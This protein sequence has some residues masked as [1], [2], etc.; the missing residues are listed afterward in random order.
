MVIVG[1]FTSRQCQIGLPVVV[2]RLLAVCEEAGCDGRYIAAM[3]TLERTLNEVLGKNLVTNISAAIGAALAEPARPMVAIV[4]GSKVSTKLTVLETLSDKVDR[5]I[6][7]GGINGAVA[8]A[9]L[10]GCGVRVALID[11]GD[12]AAD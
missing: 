6:V 3:A 11:R 12:F 9:S 4:G 5:L 2:K 1:E 7:G 8:A 10:A